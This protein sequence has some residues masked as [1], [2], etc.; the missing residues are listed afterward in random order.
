M[1]VGEEEK[2]LEG[3]LW[4]AQEL[5][6]LVHIYIS[7]ELERRKREPAWAEGNQEQAVIMVGPISHLEPGVLEEQ[8][9]KEVYGGRGRGNESRRKNRTHTI[10]RHTYRWK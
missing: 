6:R 9:E 3:D 1:A 8:N 7:S 10:H 2:S 5:R 4:R